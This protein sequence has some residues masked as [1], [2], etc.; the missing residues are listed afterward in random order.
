[1]DISA[2]APVKETWIDGMLNLKDEDFD[3]VT[4]KY[5]NLLVNF[6]MYLC[7]DCKTF[8]NEY[9]A[10]AHELKEQDST[11]VLAI[12]MDGMDGSPNL[13]AERFGIEKFPTLY[14]FKN[15]VE[16]EY[17]GLRSKESL[18]DFVNENSK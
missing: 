17:T 15:G 2:D 7:G 16:E 3:Q 1:M 9:I 5:P 6:S 10:A 18:V 11:A 4:A 12:A 13:L 14:W 8:M